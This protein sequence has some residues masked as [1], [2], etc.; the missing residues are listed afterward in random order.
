M[1]FK[2]HWIDVAEALEQK[3][4]PRAILERPKAGGDR[5]TNAGIF[6]TSRVGRTGEFWVP[7]G[8]I[9]DAEIKWEVTSQG[10]HVSIPMQ[11]YRTPESAKS[12]LAACAL[13]MGLRAGFDLARKSPRRPVEVTLVLGHKVDVV[14]NSYRYYLGLAVRVE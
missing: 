11:A 7:S 14:D 2:L 5:A 10:D 12:W 9:N 1:D 13:E 3:V 4:Q 6:G 8:P